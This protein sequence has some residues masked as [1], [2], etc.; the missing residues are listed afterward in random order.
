MD[1]QICLL[2]QIPGSVDHILLN[3]IFLKIKINKYQTQHFFWYLH[4]WELKDFTN[5]VS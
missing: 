1:L 3:K 4:V 2:L 5:F